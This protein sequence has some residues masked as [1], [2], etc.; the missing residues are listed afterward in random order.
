MS[1][2]RPLWC[3]ARAVAAG[4]RVKRPS[5]WYETPV[6][7]LLPV[8]RP[9]IRRQTCRQGRESRQY[10]SPDCLACRKPHVVRRLHSCTA[11]ICICTQRPF[12]R[13]HA[14]MCTT[15]ICVIRATVSAL[16]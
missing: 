4:A 5:A 15:W 11:P 6:L 2:M 1:H 9:Q 7:L 14:D 8:V 13:V 16:S 3:A 10:C 12:S